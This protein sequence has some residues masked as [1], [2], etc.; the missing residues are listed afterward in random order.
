MTIPNL[1]SL[2]FVLF[3]QQDSNSNRQSTKCTLNTWPPPPRPI[4]ILILFNLCADVD[5][6]TKA[7]QG[8]ATVYA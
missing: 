6:S 8:P 7:A 1:F 3:K 2:F 5:P 4:P